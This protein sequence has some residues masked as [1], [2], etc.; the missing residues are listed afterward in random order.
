MLANYDLSRVP[1]ALIKKIRTFIS[2]NEMTPEKCKNSSKSAH[3]LYLWVQDWID[4]AEAS[5]QLGDLEKEMKDINL[6]IE[7][8]D[9][10][11]KEE[12]K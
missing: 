10:D 2:E 9:A 5:G 12:Q 7:V 8:F 1:P 4:A 11:N 6:A 3:A